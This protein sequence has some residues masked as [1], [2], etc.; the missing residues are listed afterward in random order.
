MYVCI[1]SIYTP[2][3][4]CA[5]C[6]LPVPH[7]YIDLFL[8]G[9]PISSNTMCTSAQSEPRKMGLQSGLLPPRSLRRP[10]LTLSHAQTHAARGISQRV[11]DSGQQRLGRYITRWAGHLP[12]LLNLPHLTHLRHFTHPH[13]SHIHHLSYL[14]HHP[15]RPDCP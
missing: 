13:L 2:T 9:R 7:L 6:L 12:H 8:S 15:H 4:S 1:Y 11:I 14:P 10:G 3:S 5:C